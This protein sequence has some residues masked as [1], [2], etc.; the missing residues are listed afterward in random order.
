[1][2][3]NKA[4][5]DYERIER[6]TLLKKEAQGS[7]N[8]GVFTS[9]SYEATNKLRAMPLYSLVG[10]ALDVVVVIS[11][12]LASGYELGIW[13]F[14][15]LSTTN[16]CFTCSLFDLVLSTVVKDAVV[17]FLIWK[18]RSQPLS[19]TW[20]LV[21]IFLPLCDLAFHCVKLALVLKSP[22]GPDSLYGLSDVGIVLLSWS[23][24]SSALL[25]M[26]VLLIVWMSH[27]FVAT[28]GNRYDP[29]ILS[30][31]IDKRS[32]EESAKIGH[33]SFGRLL[34]LASPEIPYLTIAF[35]GLL[36]GSA[37]NLALP[38]FFGK[39]M[40]SLFNPD[41]E[42]AKEGLNSNVLTLL[43]ICAVSSVFS[44]IQTFLFRIVGQKIVV[45]LRKL[46]FESILQQD[47]S[48][49]DETKTGELTNR[50]S[51]D[52]KVIEEVMT[53]QVGLALSNIIS[54]LGS[55]VLIFISS[56]KLT[57]VMLSSVP[58]IAVAGAIYGRYMKQVSEDLQKA[59]AVASS[60]AEESLSA[61]RTVRSFVCEEKVQKLY[62][63]DIHGSYLIG[64]KW[65]FLY[66]LFI[67]LMSVFAQGAIILVVWYGG[68]LVLDMEFAP[69]Q[70]LSF[71]LYTLSVAM[72]FAGF[73]STIG[74]FMTGI[75]AAERIFQIIDTEPSFLSTSL[76]TT[77]K[78]GEQM[79]DNQDEGGYTFENVEG[80]IR[81]ENVSFAYPSRLDQ[82]VLKDL[83]I[84]IK[85]GQVV[86]LVGPSGGGKSTVVSLLQRFYKPL[87]GNIT[88]DGHPIHKLDP[89]WYHSH[90]SLVAQEPTLFAGTIR[91]N[92]L[93]GSKHLHLDDTGMITAAKQANAHEFIEKFPDGY[94]TL[95]GERGV[96][97]S[98][99]QKQRVAIARA[100]LG[101]PRILLLDEA[102]SALDA[103]S[104]HKVQEAIDNSITG[105]TV[106]IVAHRLSTVKNA[107]KVIVIKGGQ[108]AEEGTH[109]ELLEKNGLYC[110]LVK[111]QMQS[112]LFSDEK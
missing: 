92:I 72:A 3:I 33:A 110:K 4:P 55:I 29:R 81:F 46:T 70:L 65:S 95:V 39:I 111:R 62:E 15:Q 86:A 90:I 34:K 64:K 75:G 11:L 56:W 89:S 44:F 109:S 112:S 68:K 77:T 37:S 36:L 5:K 7:Q 26:G 57:L 6:K 96:Q 20:A 45:R 91:E 104:E 16:Y 67:A 85:P 105:R 2:E 1:M 18:L 42:K 19:V 48:F 21:I 59:L 87:K 101:N 31:L 35:V 98:G 107:S 50:L 61:I 9:F 47:I 52:A 80:A 100:L 97:L 28:F 54:A 40:E 51:S 58:L 66:A 41:P 69:G 53:T 84:D 23:L 8:K 99:G 43:I 24:A 106:L 74:E 30:T 25:C 73:S 83:N 49:F 79:Y 103:E 13:Q 78:N 22:Q 32:T 108:V 10:L 27:S 102:T 71:L 93:F 88:L 63:G 12:W 17:F 76:E 14:L 94:D 82:P 60:T 38:N